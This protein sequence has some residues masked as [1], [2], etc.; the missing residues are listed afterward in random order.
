MPLTPDILK[1]YRGVTF[2]ETGSYQGEA[3]GFALDLGFLSIHTIEFDPARAAGVRNRFHNNPEV[4]VYD[5]DSAKILPW[6]LQKAA[7]VGPC[8]CWLDGHPE[9]TLTPDNTPLLAELRCLAGHAKLHRVTVLIDDIR[10]FSPE[11]L[12]Q[13]TQLIVAEFPSDYRVKFL[14][15]HIA[16]GDIMLVHVP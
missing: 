6:I 8:T 1:R 9:G 10:L 4:R 16:T 14:D 7:G 11:L 15:N 3:V 12:Q 13:A 2:I 5:G